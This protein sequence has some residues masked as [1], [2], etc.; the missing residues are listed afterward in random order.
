MAEHQV[1]YTTAARENAE[2]P[3]W[4]QCTCGQNSGW[5]V[6]RQ[7]CEDWAVQHDLQVQR[8]IAALRR[9][10]PSLESQY[11]YYRQKAD[12]TLLPRAERNQWEMLAE[13][14]RHRLPAAK[15]GNDEGQTPL[16]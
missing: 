11:N 8:A 12:D 9:S 10:N 15:D 4:A 13:G 1:K 16:F 5:R 3:H 2:R 14:L 7:D 6:S